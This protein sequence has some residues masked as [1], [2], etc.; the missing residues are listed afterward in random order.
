MRLHDLR[1]TY[2]SYLVSEGHSLYE[3]QQ[4]LGHSD[5]RMTTRYAHFSQDKLAKATESVARLLESRPEREA[6]KINEQPQ[7]TL[8][9]QPEAC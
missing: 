9:K 3:T 8:G 1:H 5:P 4:L 6:G 2:A 7:E